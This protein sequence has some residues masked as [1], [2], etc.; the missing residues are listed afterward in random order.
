[1]GVG[2]DF[3][4]KNALIDN[5]P[6]SILEQEA[7]DFWQPY[8]G[9]VYNDFCLQMLENG[10]SSLNNPKSRPLSKPKR[11]LFSKSCAYNGHDLAI[12]RPLPSKDYSLFS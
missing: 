4:E 12:K 5:S 2:I 11:G 9:I 7:I 8:R 6:G 10:C 3:C 1:M